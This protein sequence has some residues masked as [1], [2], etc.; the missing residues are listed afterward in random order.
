VGHA[1]VP[2]VGLSQLRRELAGPREPDLIALLLASCS[3]RLTSIARASVAVP[4]AAARSICG[5]CSGDANET[6]RRPTAIGYY[7]EL[8][9]A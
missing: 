8:L 6:F 9:T 3:P 1:S 5:L 2:V 7:K 4:P